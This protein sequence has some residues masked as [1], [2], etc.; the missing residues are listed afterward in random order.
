MLLN[1]N[2]KNVRPVDHTRHLSKK[3]PKTIAKV[4]SGNPGLIT[5]HRFPKKV[6]LVSKS[7]VFLKNKVIKFIFSTD[8]AN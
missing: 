1:R 6:L 3:N 8:K 5:S 2:R 4:A 7:A